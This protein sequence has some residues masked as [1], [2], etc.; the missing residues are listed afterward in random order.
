MFYLEASADD[1]VSAGGDEALDVAEEK[2]VVLLEESG[3][4]V[5]HLTGVVDYTELL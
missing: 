1:G 5:C 4:I 2:I 3:D